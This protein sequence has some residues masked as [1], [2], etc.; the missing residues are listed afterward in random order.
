M[1]WTKREDEVET[2]IGLGNIKAS[3]DPIRF[4]FQNPFVT[5][6]VIEIVTLNHRR[7]TTESTHE[8]SLGM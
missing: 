4:R 6:I 7:I 8:L 5:E 2:D 3:D 1:D